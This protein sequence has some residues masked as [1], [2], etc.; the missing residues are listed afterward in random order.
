MRKKLI[1]LLSLL[2]LAATL[3]S[4]QKQPDTPQP[5]GTLTKSEWTG[6]LGDKFGYH[7]YES[8]VDFYSDVSP[9]HNYYDEIQACAEWEILPEQGVF[10][11]DRKATWRY[12]IETS[13]RAIGIEK[14]NNAN[15]DMEVTEDNLVE[16]FTGKIA[17]VDSELL[18]SGLSE[19]EASM[20]LGYAYDYAVNLVLPQRMEYTYK[21]EVKEASAE[22]VALKGDGVTAIVRDGASYKAG[23]VIYVQA[24]EENIPYAIR[25][26]SVQGNQITYE[27]AG[28]DDVYEEI[29]VSGTYEATVIDVEPAPGVTVSMGNPSDRQAFAY[30]SFASSSPQ[31]AEYL[32]NASQI[33]GKDDGV[34]LTGVRK[35]GNSVRFDAKLDNGITFNVTISDI[36]ASADIDYGFLSVKKANATVSFNDSI[37]AEYKAEHASRQVPLG[38]LNVALGTTAVSLKISLVANLGFDGEVTLSYSSKVVGMVNYQQKKGLAASVSNENPVFDY[39]A[40][41]TIT[42][43]PCV[44]AEICILGR[45]IANVKVISGVVAIVTED[46]DLMGKEPSCRDVFMYVPLRWA[47]NEDG[48][49]LTTFNKKLKASEVVWD[50]ENSP[51]TLR[52]HWENGEQVE[53]CTRGKNKV[54][55]PVVDEDGDPYDEY[56]IFDFEEIVFGFIKVASQKLYL[57]N[58]ES[59]TVGILAVPDGYT[60]GSLVY[61]VENPAVCTV[62]GGVVTA[63]GSGSTV[64]QISTP[65]G[66]YSVFVTVMVE[67]EYNDTSGFQPL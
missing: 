10:Q 32:N 51:I 9:D 29:Q 35:E 3:C 56:K 57:S 36:M 31:K 60:A 5:D 52:M 53:V 64:L 25:V 50:S 1:F 41:A 59:M 20:I 4:C 19:A 58:G 18:E 43:E 39:H 6:L 24:S 23:D 44:K 30:A 63:V 65:D 11:P 38:T 49:I 14:L 17:H 54:E 66:K 37:T 48:C 13:V 47:V 62:S 55:T 7:A 33:S 67:I 40:D 16:F 15:V 8:T 12:A 26:N 22:A 46:S 2:L 34:V 28:I 61:K 42:V 45:G 21:E 27:E